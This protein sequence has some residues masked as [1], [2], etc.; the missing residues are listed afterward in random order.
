MKLEEETEK[1]KEILEPN[2]NVKKVYK[3]MSNKL[4][5]KTESLNTND[6]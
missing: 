5:F 4:F 6:T 3:H 1:K 2:P